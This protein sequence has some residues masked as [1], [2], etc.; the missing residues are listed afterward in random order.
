MARKRVK[1]EYDSCRWDEE[2]EMLRFFDGK[3]EIDS[4]DLNDLIGLAEAEGNL[5][6]KD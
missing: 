1:R 5:V 6:E 4:F 3:E 2:N